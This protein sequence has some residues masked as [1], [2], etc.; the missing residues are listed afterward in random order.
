MPNLL[1]LTGAG[2]SAE[3]GISTF[4]DHDGLWER[5]RFE[6]LATPEVFARDQI[7]RAHV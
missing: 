1:V 3:S 2:I 5:H 7:G 6:D 4:R